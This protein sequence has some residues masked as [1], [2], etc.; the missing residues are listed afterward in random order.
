MEAINAFMVKHLIGDGLS[1]NVAD[2]AHEALWSYIVQHQAHFIEGSAI[3]WSKTIDCRGRI[4]D[5]RKGTGKEVSFKRDVLCKIFREGLGY[6]NVDVILD[7]FAKKGWTNHE[8]G[9]SYSRRKI[10][11]MDPASAQ[12]IVVVFPDV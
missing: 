3:A 9:K 2:R 4:T 8:K 6:Q 12:A 5:C 1:R 10:T 11:A 7:A